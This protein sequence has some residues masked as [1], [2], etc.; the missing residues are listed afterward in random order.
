VCCCVLL[1]SAAVKASPGVVWLEEN[2]LLDVVL[3]ALCDFIFRVPS[4]A[5]LQVSLRPPTFSWSMSVS[6]LYCP[7][8]GTNCAGDPLP[9]TPHT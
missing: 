3:G 8:P 9:H 4:L 1:R 7:L 5:W 2:T 6:M